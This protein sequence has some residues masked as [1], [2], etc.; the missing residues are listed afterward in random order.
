MS[1][2]TKTYKVTYKTYFNERLK[3]VYFHGKQTYPLYVQVTFDRRTIFFKSYYFELFSKPRYYLMAAGKSGGPSIDAVIKKET[4][5]LDF[6]ADKVLDDFSL[7][8]FKENYLYYS[9]DLCDVTEPGFVDYLRTFFHDKGMST[10]GDVI[11]LGCK[12]KIAYDIVRSMRSAFEKKLYSELVENSFY[13]SPPYIPL[14]GFM[15]LTK[16]WPMLS[17]SVMEW[18][19]GEC[20]QKYT[21]Y[22]AKYYK[23][24]GISEPAEQVNAWLKR[25]KKSVTAS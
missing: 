13:Y 1:D 10:L 6:V 15:E 20:E 2:H 7:E 19:V 17:L 12:Q 9:A 16:R 8:R 18:E 25:L 4:E 14:F 11:A 23:E 22:V 3:K 21:A 24:L 5:V